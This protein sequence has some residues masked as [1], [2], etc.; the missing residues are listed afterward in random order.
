MKKILTLLILL[1]L[2]N[3]CE[4]IVIGQKTPIKQ[5]VIINYNQKMSEGVIYLFQAEID[6]DNSYSAVDLLANNN[7]TIMLAYDRYEKFYE[8]E[9]FKRRNM[10]VPIT[11]IRTNQVSNNKSIKV[12]EYDLYRNIQFNVVKID[13]LWYIV[14]ILENK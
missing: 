7:G 14:D 9:R 4:I 10:N 3:S 11:N 1:N 12:V 6:N 5:K 2:L 8:I 13:T